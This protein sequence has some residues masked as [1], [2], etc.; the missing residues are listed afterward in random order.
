MT[1]LK[2]TIIG[3]FSIVL[4]LLLLCVLI[5]FATKDIAQA[6]LSIYE[7][8]ENLY[9]LDC[10]YDYGFDD[11]LKKGGAKSDEELANYLVQKL[12]FGLYKNTSSTNTASQVSSIKE[13]N[14][15]QNKKAFGCST[16]CAKNNKGEVLFGRNY[17]WKAGKSMIIRT[18]PKNGYAS[19]STC[20]LDFLGFGENFNPIGTLFERMQTL[21]AI[22]VP[23]D[24]INEMGL[25]VADLIIDDNAC[26]NQNTDKKDLTTTTA[27]RLLLDK[28]A[29]VD[30][31]VALLNQYDMHSS[32]NSMHHL[33]IADKTGKSVVAEYVND[34]LVITETSVVTNFYLSQGEK[35]GVGSKQSHLRF[36]TLK[37]GIIEKSGNAKNG[38]NLENFTTLAVLP[39]GID[40]VKELLQSVMQKNYT[41]SNAEFEQNVWSHAYNLENQVVECYFG[42]NFDHFYTFSPHGLLWLFKVT[43]ES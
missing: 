24:G 25:V 9:A 26:T 1:L 7:L 16:L 27:I 22:Y 12:S 33:A 28:A 32:Y 11:F 21:A 14:A 8:E 15:S 37:K 31:A 3:F 19:V 30:E 29:N 39:N 4:F 5:F 34:Q 41:Q 20:Y 43:E 23:L 42:E 6:A 10:T 35:L 40:D 18:T 36:E 17:D 13:T 38:E 2:K